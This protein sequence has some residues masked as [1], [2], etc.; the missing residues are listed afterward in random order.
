MRKQYIYKV[1]SYTPSTF[2]S[3]E[4]LTREELSSR[5]TYCFEQ[6]HTEITV[7]RELRKGVPFNPTIG[8]AGK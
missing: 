4:C 3:R 7:T 2:E 1:K 6:R 5:L 8:L